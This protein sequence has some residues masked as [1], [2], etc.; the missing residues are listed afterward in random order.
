MYQ[1]IADSAVALVRH[2]QTPAATPVL[3]RLMNEVFRALQSLVY[4]VQMQLL[5][6]V[7]YVG[8]ALYFLHSCWLASIYCFEYR[9]VH[10]QWTSKQRLEY[11]ESHWLY[12]AG[13]GFPMSFICYCCPR[14]VDTGVFALLFPLCILKATTAKPCRLE[15]APRMWRRLPVFVFVQGL[16]SY[17]LKA[18]ESQ[19]RPAS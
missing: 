13:F 18:F 11:F 17:V 10:L 1:E 12:F 14:F 15:G 9:W 19:L 8:P 2:R 5:A 4:I 3:T 6:Y 7:P 16:S